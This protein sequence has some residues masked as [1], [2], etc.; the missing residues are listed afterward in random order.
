M[1][2]KS[3]SNYKNCSTYHYLYQKDKK[4]EQKL[5]QKLI[6]KKNKI[7]ENKAPG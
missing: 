3:S 4:K 5:K 2:F 1:C 7:D 6:Q